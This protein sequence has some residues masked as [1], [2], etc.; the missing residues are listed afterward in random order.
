MPETGLLGIKRRIKSINNTKKI[1][2][3]VGMIAVTKLKRVKDNLEFLRLYYEGY[4]EIISNA[5]ISNSRDLASKNVTELY[6][7]IT[8]DSGLCGNYNIGIIQE[9]LKEIKKKDVLLIILG[10]IGR[11]FFRRKNYEVIAEYIEVGITPNIKDI[12]L[13]TNDIITAF[14]S[15]RIGKA[16]IIYTK[17]I[18][19]LKQS[20]EIKELTLYHESKDEI[21]TIIYEPD[22]NSAM[23]FILPKYITATLFYCIMSSTASEYSI[24]V[25]AMDEATKNAS[26][27]I[28]RL[29]SVYNRIRQSSI[30]REI[31]EIVTGAEVL[32]D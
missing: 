21:Q 9:A 15:R 23:E 25:R 2:K 14:T 10:Q 16:S 8:S 30:T 5:L 13:I 27:M 12:V 31:N 24:R 7:I 1:T 3:A 4:E 20:I 6:I 11:N 32:K 29:K 22:Y 17:Y 19:P 18:S 28:D 26:D